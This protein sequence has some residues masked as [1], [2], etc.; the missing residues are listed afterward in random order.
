MGR[1]VK[2]KKDKVKI[3]MVNSLIFPIFLYSAQTREAVYRTQMDWIFQIVVLDTT[4]K[5]NG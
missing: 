5:N 3:V 1:L 4:M 2:K